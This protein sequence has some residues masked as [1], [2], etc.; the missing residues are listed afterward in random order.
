LARGSIQRVQRF[1]ALVVRVFDICSGIGGFSLGLHATGGFETVA[2]CEYD[3]FCR[4]I[5]EKNF[6]GIPIFNDLKE[7]ANDEETIRTIPYFDLICGGIPC[8]PWSVAGKKKGTQD[9]RHLWPF[10]LEIIK[11]K[12]P[13]YAVIENVG[14]FINVALDLVCFDLEAEGYATQSFV[15]P[16][17]SV[18]APHRRDRVWIIGRKEDASDPNNSG[19]RA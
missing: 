9:D 16:A 5:L 17:C 11:Q 1:G 10:M 12:K 6:P 7:L 4:N 19:V 8:Q 3:P 15:I 2:F 14:G 18:Q 13:T